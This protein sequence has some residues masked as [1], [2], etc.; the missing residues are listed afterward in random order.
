MVHNHSWEL[1]GK[2]LAE[3]FIRTNQPSQIASSPKKK[4]EYSAPV[5]ACR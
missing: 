2:A 4:K 3:A 1:K 5:D